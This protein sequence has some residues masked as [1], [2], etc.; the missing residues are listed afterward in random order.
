MEVV[1]PPS[2]ELTPCIINP[3][4]STFDVRSVLQTF[5]LSQQTDMIQYITVSSM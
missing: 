2:P 3:L 5:D 4:Q 1:E